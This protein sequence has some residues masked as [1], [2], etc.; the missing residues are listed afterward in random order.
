MATVRERRKKDGTTIFNAQ[1]RMA[2][3][4]ARTASFPTKRLAER[5]SK[6]IEAQMIEGRHFRNPEA[7]R[8][9][10]AEAI[11]RYTLEVLPAK[12]TQNMHKAAL[13]WWRE[14]IGTLKLADVTQAIIIEKRGMLIR[15]KYQRAKPESKRSTVAEGESANEFSRTPSTVNRYTACLSHLFT[16][17]RKD[18]G[19]AI[20]NPMEEVT[21]LPEKSDRARVL[22]TDERKRLYEK[23]SPDPTLHLF[24]VLALSTA[25]RAGELVKLK[26]RDVDLEEGKLLFS[27]TKNEQPRSAWLHGDA[28]KL[29]VAHAARGQTP[30]GRVFVNASGRGRYQ[31]AKLFEAA[32][33]AAGIDGFVFHN[34]RHSA[35]TYLAREGASEQQLKAIGGWKSGVV[36]R[37]VHIA[38]A[39][40]R[41]VVEQMNKK[42]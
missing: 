8:R 38:A 2:G 23:T 12:R 31:Y 24:V 19:W 33:V 32:C 28:K 14:K 16:V 13:A 5:W 3:F 39:D 11:D 26:W 6:T 37:Y 1:V 29:M 25:C 7:R 10:L 42:L 41:A 35:A 40:T 4:P 21:K 20:H 34:L 27:D 22:S 9:T 36:S 17:A 18:W 30:D 15:D